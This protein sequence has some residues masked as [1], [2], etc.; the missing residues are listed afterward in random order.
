MTA[1]GLMMAIMFIMCASWVEPFLFMIT[2]GAA[3]LINLG[4]NIF[5][6]SISEVTYSIAAIL[7]LILSMDYSIILLGFYRQEL[8]H[9]EDRLSAMTNALVSAAA[10]VSASGMTTVAGLVVLVFM[11]FKIGMDLGLVLAKG[12]FLSM[13][14]VF[15]LLPA[16]ILAF[17]KLVRLTAKKAPHIRAGGLAGLSYRF[18]HVVLALLAVLFLGSYILQQNTEMMAVTMQYLNSE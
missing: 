14:C 1:I 5:L 3:V 7:Q 13:F 4:T 10:S 2:I 9:N 6:G 18:R 11:R 8:A 12:V 16:L 15:T 17:D